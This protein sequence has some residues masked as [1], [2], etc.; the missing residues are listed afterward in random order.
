MLPRPRIIFTAFLTALAFTLGACAGTAEAEAADGDLGWVVGAE[1]A[2]SLIKDGEVT[3]LDARGGSAFTTEHIK[4]SQ[5][6]S[7]QEFTKAEQAKRGELLAAKQVAAKLRYKGV[8]NDTP[9]LVVGD[10]KNGWGEE[11]RIVWM[12]KTLKHKDAALIDG[13]FAALKKAGAPTE[14]G[15]AQKAK[16]G[17]FTGTQTTAY[18]ASA[19]DVKEAVEK[20]SAVLVDTRE[21][22]EYNG[23][24]PYGESRG[25]HVP[26]AVHLHYKDLLASDGTLKSRAAIRKKMKE[27]GVEET[28]TPII[29]YCTGGVR[30]AWFV[31]VLRH[32]GFDNVVNYAGSMWEWASLEA[33]TYPLEK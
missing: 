9:V 7:W 33:D 2:T 13:G 14:K 21:E 22:R 19:E 11:G 24:T 15:A 32:A 5:P 10:P 16:T 26:T 8:S 12:L 18:L 28:E 25:G 31:A 27:L 20:E 30:S 6:V 23:E 17:D 3:V 1:R 29:A 4:G